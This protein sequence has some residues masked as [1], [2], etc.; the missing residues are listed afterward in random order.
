MA[1]YWAERLLW[2]SLTG[3]DE[4]LMCSHTFRDPERS[5]QMRYSWLL[6]ILCL[7]YVVPAH[8]GDHYGELLRA[9]HPVGWWRFE[10]TGEDQWRDHSGSEHHAQLRG[11]VRADVAGPRPSEYPDFTAGNIGAAFPKG[12]NFL[13]VS[14]S[15]DASVLD[16]GRGDA[17]TLEAWVQMEGQRPVVIR[18][19]SVKAAPGTAG[20]QPI[21]RTTPCGWPMKPPGRC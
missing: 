14:D 16:F 21:T 10:G 1:G 5:H 19:S 9:D 2:A 13:V 12:P 11:N 20:S 15:G 4:E 7:L 18:T 3:Y 8:G 6:T 17:I